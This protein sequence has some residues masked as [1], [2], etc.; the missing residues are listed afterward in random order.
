MKN[1]S[2]SQKQGKQVPCVVATTG[3]K[4]RPDNANYN[5]LTEKAIKKLKN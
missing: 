4:A 3:L 1:N 2:N 5:L